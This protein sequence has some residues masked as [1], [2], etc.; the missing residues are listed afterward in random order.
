MRT[1]WQRAI[2]ESALTRTTK[3]VAFTL[4]TFMNDIATCYPSLPRLAAGA[5]VDV[6]TVKRHLA[7]LERAEWVAR[8]RGGGRQKT[9]VYTGRIPARACA[10]FD[11]EEQARWCARS[12]ETG[13]GSAGNRRRNRPK[14]AQDRPETGAPV[15]LEV[16]REVER[17]GAEGGRTKRRASGEGRS[18]QQVNG[19]SHRLGRAAEIAD[20]ARQLEEAGQ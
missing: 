7:T 2:R 16:E 12:E 5:S 18:Q 6:A 10:G 13:A 11:T 1:V 17:E 3:L 19:Y 20:W 8:A 4:G 14:P 9:T 15:R